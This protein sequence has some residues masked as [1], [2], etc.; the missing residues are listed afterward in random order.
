MR[1]TFFPSDP[2]LIP[3]LP[4]QIQ[5]DADLH[6]ATLAILSV[7]EEHARAQEEGD[8][9]TQLERV[10]RDQLKGETDELIAAYS[11]SVT[12]VGDMELEKCF[13]S[14]CWA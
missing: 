11:A 8:T 1:P 3:S 10:F 7:V 13:S 5:L 9:I 2:N 4:H 6:D 14:Y 12:E